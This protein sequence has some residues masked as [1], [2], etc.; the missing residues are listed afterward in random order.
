MTLSEAFLL[1]I[2]WLHHVAAVLWVGGGLFYLIVLR[3]ILRT[4]P[5][6][7]NLRETVALHFRG[8]L[9]ICILIL[10][11]TGTLLM[12]DRLTPGRV[13]SIYVFVLVVKILGALWMFWAALKRTGLTTSRASRMS[14]PALN[15]VS[16]W[17][18]L[19]WLLGLLTEG[20]AVVFV[21]LGLLLLADVLR[22]IVE[23]SLET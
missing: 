9:H 14:P 19:K 2:R 6:G 17:I 5:T 7:E 13:G 4:H 10:L 1:L 20:R 8:V 18:P 11:V 21:G 16:N 12:V 22:W 15:R 3:P 23:H